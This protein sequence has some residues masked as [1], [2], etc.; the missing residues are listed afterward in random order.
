MT[1]FKLLILK[2]YFTGGEWQRE[3]MTE[4][5]TVIRLNAYKWGELP[6]VPIFVKYGVINTDYVD[7]FHLCML[8][9]V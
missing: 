3:R 5:I 4:S 8:M 9:L 6:D 2:I 1:T 7:K